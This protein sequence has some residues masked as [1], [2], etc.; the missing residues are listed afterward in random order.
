MNFSFFF[1]ESVNY[2][3]NID[4]RISPNHAMVTRIALLLLREKQFKRRGVNFGMAKTQEGEP[5]RVE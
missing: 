1:P 3:F 5:Q 4:S 2:Q